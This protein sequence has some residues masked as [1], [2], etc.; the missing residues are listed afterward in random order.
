MTV[1]SFPRSDPASPEFWEMRYRAAF[2]PWDA[3]AVPAPLRDFVAAHPPAGPILVP[4]CG[5]GHDVRFLAE[6]GF[7]VLGIDFSRA[8]LDAAAPVVGP[9]AARLRHAD[10]FA[11]GLEGPWA[12]VYERAFLC[13]LPR[14]RWVEWARRV[15]GILAPGGLLAGFFF[16]GDGE[17]GPPYPLL[18]Q[19]ELDGLLAGAFERT[20]D[21]PVEESVPVFAQRERWQVWARRT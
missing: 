8:A 11:P 7:D 5:S 21:L 15:A 4:G 12:L 6:A 3:G 16:F 1:P 20:A 10:F 2:T 18:G 17:R 9:F 14:R 13:S 19:E